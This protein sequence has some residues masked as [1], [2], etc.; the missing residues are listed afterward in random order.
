M[1]HG[2]NG[3]SSASKASEGSRTSVECAA[4]VGGIIT[5][6]IIMIMLI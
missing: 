2:N 1:R 3:V 6:N 5:T 4:T